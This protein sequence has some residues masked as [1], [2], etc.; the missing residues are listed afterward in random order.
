MKKYIRASESEQ[1]V[2]EVHWQ[3]VDGQIHR[4]KVRGASRID[5]LKKMV[6]KM[7]GGLYV[8]VDEIDS[9]IEENGEDHAW[10]E[11]INTIRDTNGDGCNYVFYLYD[12][13]ADE[14]VIDEALG[15]DE[16]WE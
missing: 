1:Y 8:Y 2:L 10:F 11:A 15:D 7:N 14:L 16:D 9:D 3:D 4:A 6:N 13:T 5:A 12:L